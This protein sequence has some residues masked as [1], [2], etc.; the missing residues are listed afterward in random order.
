MYDHTNH[1]GICF[2][3]SAKF[4]ILLFL[5][6]I[7]KISRTLMSNLVFKGTDYIEKTQVGTFK[8]QT[9]ANV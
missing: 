8:T 4:Y 2:F 7:L 9:H 1:L 3:F 5:L 6:G